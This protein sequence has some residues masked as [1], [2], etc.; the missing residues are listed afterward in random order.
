VWYGADG[1]Y[2]LWPETAAKLLQ[3]LPQKAG[4]GSVLASDDD[5]LR[6]LAADGVVQATPSALFRIRL[7]GHDRPQPAV[8]VREGHRILE[9]I[10]RRTTPIELRAH[11]RIGDAAEVD[12][13]ATWHDCVGADESSPAEV[14]A[15]HALDFSAGSGSTPPSSEPSEPGPSL[16]VDTS[17][18]TN[19]R[20]REVVDGVITRLDHSFNRMQ[21][22]IVDG[23][24]FVALA[25]FVGQHGDGAAVVRSLHD[26][27]LLAIDDVTAS[28]RVIRKKIEGVEVI[29]VVLSASALQG[30]VEWKRRWQRAVPGER[31]GE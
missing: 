26:A 22:S 27:G 15:Q 5:L 13:Q 8:R 18:I 9:A 7:P 30:Y 29:G 24:V 28:R 1:L 3:A 12:D 16:A 17:K 6:Q 19:P 11:E 4:S 31:H 20:I 14:P 21:S 23:G 2:L 25:E 10:S